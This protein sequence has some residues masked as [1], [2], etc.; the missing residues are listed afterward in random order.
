VLTLYWKNTCRKLHHEIIFSNNIHYK[1]CNTWK[2]KSDVYGPD[3]QLR[4]KY[5]V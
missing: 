2:K 3:R 1:L 4:L 5:T